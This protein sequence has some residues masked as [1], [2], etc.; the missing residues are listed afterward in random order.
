MGYRE[1]RIGATTLA[2]TLNLVWLGCHGVGRV[3]ANVQQSWPN[4][5]ATSSR[6]VYLLNRASVFLCP[7]AF[8]A[9]IMPS[10]LIGSW[11]SI[12][13]QIFR[14]SST[15]LLS[16]SDKEKYNLLCERPGCGHEA[17]P[18]CLLCRSPWT[19]Y[20]HG[21]E[22]EQ[23]CCHGCRSS[24]CRWYRNMYLRLESIEPR[25]WNSRTSSFFRRQWIWSRKRRHP[26]IKWAYVSLAKARYQLMSGC[27]TH[28]GL[29]TVAEN[30][31]FSAQLKYNIPRTVILSA[32]PSKI[33]IMASRT[34]SLDRY[35]VGWGHQE[36]YYT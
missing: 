17:H 25:L 23:C 1:I 16:R 3:C 33:W 20:P 2:W 11:P 19:R 8:T 6:N 21:H 27:S 7:Y 36:K 14:L 24:P 35:L 9:S 31:P 13:L 22:V 12:D 30:S 4:S 10:S 26:S 32:K 18:L 34:F 15:R 29:G 28:W 5:I